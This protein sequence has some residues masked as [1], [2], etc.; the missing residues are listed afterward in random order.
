MGNFGPLALNF[1]YHVSFG[2]GMGV[3]CMEN[4]I[5]YHGS[6]RDGEKTIVDVDFETEWWQKEPPF[7]VWRLLDLRATEEILL[8]KG[9]FLHPFGM[10]GRLVY[11]L[12]DFT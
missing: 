5:R 10:V 1:Q 8:K 6:G 12:R 3:V 9:R 4:R 7:F 11:I 2:S